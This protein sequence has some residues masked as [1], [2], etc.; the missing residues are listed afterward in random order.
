MQW[1]PSPKAMKNIRAKVHD[2]TEVRGNR[3][4]DVKEVIVAAKSLLNS[5]AA[6]FPAAQIKSAG[7]SRRV[8]ETVSLFLFTGTYL[9]SPG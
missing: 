9:H 1:W 3:A 6:A 2:L 4:K 5:N 7:F 8:R